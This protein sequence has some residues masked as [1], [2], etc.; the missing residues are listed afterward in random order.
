M[1]NS[2]TCALITHE[3]ALKA[4]NAAV[5]KALEMDV[6]LSIAVVDKTADP[7]AFIRMQG[8]MGI[9]TDLSY[10]KARC[11]ARLG[12]APQVVEELLAQENTRV[13]EGLLGHPDFVLIGGGV[14]IYENGLLIGAIGVSGG[15][16]QQ[17]MA[18]AQAGLASLDVQSEKIESS[19]LTME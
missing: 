9:S 7:V 11:A 2:V 8:A 3:A 15:T 5:D 13:K 17:D 4:A 6:R 18:C 16:E 1:E 10:K 12:V 14:P 19:V